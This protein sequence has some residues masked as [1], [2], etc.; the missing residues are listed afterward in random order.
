VKTLPSVDLVIVGGGWTGLLMAKELG[1]RT[2]LSV[3]VLERGGPRDTADYID[4]MDE[5]DYAVRH[6]MMQ[7]FSQETVTLRH[8]DG[9]RALPLRQHGSFLPGVGVGGAGEH[10][11]AIAERMV[12]DSFELLSKTVEKYGAKKLPEDHSIQDWGITYDQMEPYYTRAEQLIG[13]SGKAGNLR[14]K[15]IEGGN[16]F[17]GWRSTEYPTPPTKIPYFSSLF[18]DTAKSLGYHPYPSPA[19]TLSTLYTNPDGVS[20]PGCTY[21]GYC[22]KFGC[23]IGAKA[24]PTNVL[25][26]VINKH[27][28]VS[29]RT[30]ANVRRIL[31]GGPENNGR[32]RGV[33]YIDAAGE[34][35]FQPAELVFL[36]SW[37]LNNTRLLL[38]SGIG[39]PYNSATGRG[40]VG[41]NL[42]HQVSFAAATAFFDKPLNR[43]MGSGASG[44]FVADLN[45]DLFDHSNLSFLRGGIFQGPSHG[46]R[47][48][49]SFGTVPHSVEARWGPDWKKAALHYYDRV[50]R[51]AFE[52]DHVAYKG[53]HLDLD[54]TY[55]DHYGD[56]LLR[57]TLDWRENERK[58]VEFVTA[59]AVEMARAM[60][61]KEVSPFPGLEHYDARRYQSTH[62]QGGTIMGKSPDVSVVNP[63]GQHWQASNVFVLGGSTFPQNSSAHLTLTLLALTLHT[64]DAVV[65]RY[66]KKPG[67]LA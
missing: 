14:G 12:P 46:Y 45:G 60:G 28:N 47:P 26:P 40:V 25:L 65:D 59:K 9:Q 62:V 21:C 49:E 15:L 22:E 27:K 6:R 43:F 51:I 38:L 33:T 2:P 17:E 5:L 10:W 55:K 30:G 44:I 34:E 7:N 11:S 35:V 29:I 18:R 37:I 4:S 41:R 42:T 67:P 31:R 56:P 53:N 24:Q 20:R 63:Y 50:G 13:T 57:M 64:A 36:A 52:G 16:I 48:I 19:A 58:M 3:V 61:A 54:P 8:S 39:E 1:S 32:A 66:L 23:M